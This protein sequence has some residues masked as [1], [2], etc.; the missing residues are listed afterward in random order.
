[1]Q[2]EVSGVPTERVREAFRVRGEER[3][4]FEVDWKQGGQYSDRI[5]GRGPRA[6]NNNRGKERICQHQGR[7]MTVPEGMSTQG[8]EITG[9]T[10]K[11]K[12]RKLLRNERCC[13]KSRKRLTR[14]ET[15]ILEQTLNISE[16][17]K[18]P[19]P[20]CARRERTI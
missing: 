9:K 3:V 16:D 12:G 2:R 19:S 13:L 6:L 11:K 10:A 8:G 18:V 7:G 5:R 1:L 17:E 4:L 20:D 15:P 14:V